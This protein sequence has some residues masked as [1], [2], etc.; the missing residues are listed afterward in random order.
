MKTVVVLIE[1]TFVCPVV[2]TIPDWWD[3]T[4]ARQRLSTPESLGALE[5]MAD[6]D[7]WEE[8]NE[9]PEIRALG[10]PGGL[11]TACLEFGADEPMPV[12]PDQLGLPV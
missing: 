8:A 6:P 3:D 11:V 2:A 12:H 1:K 10:A 9:E 7:A 4:I 5:D